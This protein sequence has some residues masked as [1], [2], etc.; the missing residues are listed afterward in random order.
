VSEIV[1]NA[2]RAARGL[3]AAGQAEAARSIVRLW[4]TVEEHG[5]FV[6]V[7][8]GNSALPEQQAPQPDAESGRGLLLVDMLSEA[9]G[10]FPFADTPGKVVWALCAAS[11][12]PDAVCADAFSTLHEGIQHLDVAEDRHSR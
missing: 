7:W 9:W 4:L 2:V 6:L 10:A 3:E 5:V 1:T 11:E 12:A 8:D